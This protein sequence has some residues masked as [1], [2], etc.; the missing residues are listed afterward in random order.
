M[1]SCA[2][3]VSSAQGQRPHEEIAMIMQHSY[4]SI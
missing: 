2:K 1:I 3:P 4:G